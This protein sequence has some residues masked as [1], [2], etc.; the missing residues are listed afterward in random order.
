MLL[1]K[2]ELINH[3]ITLLKHILH[4]R[5]ITFAPTYINLVDSIS[6]LNQFSNY[7]E[8]CQVYPKEKP[9]IITLINDRLKT[10]TADIIPTS[11]EMIANT[12]G[13]R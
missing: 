1:K 2:R 13:P 7:L 6:L 8:R 11:H 12:S 3:S 4:P 10:L 9:F 5:S